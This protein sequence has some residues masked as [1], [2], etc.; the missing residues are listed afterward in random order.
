MGKK[1]W[2]VVVGTL[3]VL[4]AA[5]G[6][7][8][9]VNKVKNSISEPDYSSIGSGYQLD[10]SQNY[11]RGI[12]FRDFTATED[13]YYFLT[14]NMLHLY[15]F[16]YA[17]KEAVIACAKPECK[18]KDNTCNAYMW[19][20]PY[21]V[22]NIYYHNG[23]LY[24]MKYESGMSVLVR[25]DTAGNNRE[26]IAKIMPSGQDAS[27]HLVFHGD[28]AY[29][30]CEYT[31]YTLDEEYTEI[32]KRISL[33]DG[34]TNNIYEVS[35]KNITVADVK[36]YG[37]RLYFAV[38]EQVEKRSYNSKTRG[39][40]AY[41][42]DTEKVSLVSDEDISDYCMIGDKNIFAYYVVGQGLYYS[43]IN[44]QTTQLVIKADK[45][46]DRCNL[47][48]DGNYVYMD[49][50]LYQIRTNS[51]A[52]FDKRCMVLTADGSKVNEIS[53]QNISTLYYGDSRCMFALSED[54]ND[55]YVYIDKK[56]I[57]NADKWVKF[58][59]K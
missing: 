15:Y 57:E 14:Q 53:C 42:Y 24:Y 10:D 52:D 44:E 22:D 23:Y 2:L 34:S 21:I 31:H 8:A 49:N 27:T 16:D 37:N 9:R 25:M 3:V 54:G 17:T 45:I 51:R 58:Y 30:Y 55:Q 6:I 46:Y 41:D 36:S 5:I 39:L 43:D 35:G 47:S 12:G 59:A 50:I 26:D 13:G 29:A 33:K 48:Y 40:Y 56:D 20:T 38:Q 11:W 1:K 18:H 7:Y 19:S 28:Y 4:A 32:I